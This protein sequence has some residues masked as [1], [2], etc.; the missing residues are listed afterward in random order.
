MRKYRGNA[1]GAKPIQE[2]RLIAAM[3]ADIASDHEAEFYGDYRPYLISDWTGPIEW[4]DVEDPEE[5]LVREYEVA[6]GVVGGRGP[7]WWKAM[8]TAH[9]PTGGATI[10]Q[11]ISTR[12]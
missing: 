3:A 9:S 5:V 8:R 1:L 12:S 2:Q 10:A 4:F 6:G 7:M 11:M